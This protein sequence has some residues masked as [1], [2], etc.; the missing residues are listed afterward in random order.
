MNSNELI[1]YAKSYRDLGFV[2]IP[3]AKNKQPIVNK[4][5][6]YDSWRMELEEMTDEFIESIFSGDPYGIAIGIPE[7]MEVLDVD[8]KYN[9]SNEPLIDQFFERITDL[10]GDENTFTCLVATPSGG[11]HV[12]YKAEGAEGNQKLSLRNVTEKEKAEGERAKVL[13]ETRGHGGYIG[14]FP[15]PGY[16]FMRGDY[17]T[18]PEIHKAYRD[19]VISVGRSFHELNETKKTEVKEQDVSRKSAWQELNEE[20][21]DGDMMFL[22]K[23]QGWELHH[24]GTGRDGQLRHYL[25]RPGKSVKAGYSGDIHVEKKLFKAHTSSTILNPDEAYT[26]FELWA[27]FE[28]NGDYTAAAK[29]L[30]KDGYG[31]RYESDQTV[32]ESLAEVDWAKQLMAEKN[33]RVLDDLNQSM[34]DWDNPPEPMKPR[35]WYTHSNGKKYKVCGYHNM[36]GLNGESGSGKT[37]LLETIMAAALSGQTHCGWSVNINGK[38]VV[39]FDTEQERGKV[40]Y[41]MNCI[42]RAA[43]IHHRNKLKVYSQATYSGAKARLEGFKAF[44]EYTDLSNVGMIVIDGIVDMCVDFNNQVES[45]ELSEYIR[46]VCVENEIILIYVLHTNTGYNKMRGHLGTMMDQKSDVIINCKIDQDRGREVTPRCYKG[47]PFGRFP[48]FNELSAITR[49]SDGIPTLVDTLI[50]KNNNEEEEW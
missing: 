40:Y 38:D 19:G 24:T 1:K 28:W 44:M 4:S 36:I 46:K 23:Q 26:F 32:E 48:E 16:V 8:E 29:A 42:A 33:Q 17:S 11:Y 34:I 13:F 50:K 14:A 45:R 22:L 9:L 41:G 43:G 47:R 10:G 2:P 21:D 35:V 25:T 18:I 7:G 31:D 20:K 3:M 39:L 6:G 37:T 12:I 15:T 5:I 27:I 30:Y 49:G